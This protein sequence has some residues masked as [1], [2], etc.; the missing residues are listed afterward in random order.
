MS[1]NVPPTHCPR[2]QQDF[3]PERRN[4]VVVVCGSC[5]WTPADHNKS[6]D[7][8][9]HKRFGIVATVLATVFTVG[10]IQ[11]VEWD[12]HAVEIVPLKLKQT[13]GSASAEDLSRIGEICIERSKL[14][15]TEQAYK[16]M[17][18][19]NPEEYARLGKF[20]FQ[21]GLF[22][23]ATWAYGN[24]F[25]KG[26]KDIEA[27]YYMARSLGEVGQ[28]D[29]AVEAYEQVLAAKPETLQVTVIQHYV[30]MLMDNQRLEQAKVLI[31]GVRE[32]SA[33]NAYFMNDD[34]KKIEEV[35]TL[36][37]KR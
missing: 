18:Q 6:V 8:G 27:R 32:K 5:G 34:F 11:T 33:T 3:S 20:Q 36:T 21:R 17:A 24:Y 37:A 22:K 25:E 35:K 7:N 15:C 13:I 16:E 26:G 29:Q 2:C 12:N 10:F 28:V 1:F 9:L 14:A 4:S 30:R 23:D 31:D 19:K